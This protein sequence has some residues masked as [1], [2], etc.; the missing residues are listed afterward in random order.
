VVK[1]LPDEVL[2]YDIARHKA[3]CLNQAAALIWRHC[4][5]ETRVGD[6]AAKLN[7]ELGLPLDEEVVV[8]A[9]DQLAKARLLEGP[10]LRPAPDAKIQRRELLKKIGVTAAVALPLVTS[11][12]AP[13]AQASTSC[14]TFCLSS[15]DCQTAASPCT[16][17]CLLAANLCIG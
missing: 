5:G 8:T 14:N 4:D 10:A 6:V 9:L 16:T 15:I 13:T 17:T 3:H 1:Q 12:L 2:V 7:E 11:L